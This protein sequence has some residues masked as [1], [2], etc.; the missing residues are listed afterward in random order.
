MS[1][2][3]NQAILDAQRQS[4]LQKYQQPYQQLGFMSDVYSGVPT[5]QATTTMT[6]GT[7]ASPFQQAAGLGIAG[8][9]AASSAK[10]LGLM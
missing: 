1:Q 5:S 9:G 3:Q 7:P 10:N 2:A 8:L 4:D 6:M